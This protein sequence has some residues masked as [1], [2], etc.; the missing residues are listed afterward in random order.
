MLKITKLSFGFESNRVLKDLSLHVKKGEIVSILGPSGCGKTTLFR[1]ISA[2][3]P[4][5]KGCISISGK[6]SPESSQDI[7]YMMQEDLLI[8]W[9]TILDNV[10]LL[11]ELGKEKK[12]LVAI[13]A[14][15]LDLLKELGLEGCES[16]YPK[17]LSGGMRQRVALARSLLQNRP[18]LLLD[19][20]FGALDFRTR[21]N[22]YQLIVNLQQRYK[23][24]ILLITH[25]FN[26]ALAL[27]HKIH[28]LSDGKLSEAWDAP[29]VKSFENNFDTHLSLRKILLQ[30]SSSHDS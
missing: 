19:E 26:D 5:Q 2:L 10:T 16:L 15:A 9:R 20:P 7:S 25:D 18:L 30:T 28:V 12:D 27:S 4:L 23:K 24:T 22:M 17:E 11:H 14:K 8:P 29:S 3:L 6:S 21:E 1:L 13:K